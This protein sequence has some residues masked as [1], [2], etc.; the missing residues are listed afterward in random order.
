MTSAAMMPSASRNR[1]IRS[2]RICPLSFALRARRRIGQ[3]NQP[4][5]EPQPLGNTRAGAGAGLETLSGSLAA[6]QR[7]QR[8]A[9]E[10]AESGQNNQRQ[11]VAEQ[12][13][14]DVCDRT[15]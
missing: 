3:Q 6:P 2:L 4:Q 9:E 13:V 1:V 14:R 10:R 11:D 7:Q 12:Q 8:F 5:P 15:P